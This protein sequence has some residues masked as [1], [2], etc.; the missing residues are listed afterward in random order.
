LMVGLL[1]QNGCYGGDGYSGHS[2]HSEHIG[3]IGRI[4]LSGLSGHRSHCKLDVRSWLY[5][6]S[7]A[8]TR[9]AVISSSVKKCW[10]TMP[11]LCAA[12]RPW[13]SLLEVVHNFS[14]GVGVGW[15]CEYTSAAHLTFVI[16]VKKIIW[17]WR[18]Q[19]YII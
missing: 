8:G 17:L 2:G 18:K 14:D 15:T 12:R 4:G 13:R 6:D 10:G 11:V 1:W 16:L 19:Y 3:H 7:G 9:L 5:S